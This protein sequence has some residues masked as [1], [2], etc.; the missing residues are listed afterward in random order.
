MNTRSEK[1]FPRVGRVRDN[2][3]YPG[4]TGFTLIEM[5]GVMAIM[6]VLATI[7]VPNTLKSIERAAVRA[8]VETLRNLGEQAK[9]YL[10]DNA[11]PPTAANWNT[12]LG[13]Y[14]SLSPG[15]IL[16][17]RRQ[18]NRIYVVD[19][20][21]ANQR[22][23]MVSSMRSGLLRQA[24]PPDTAPQVAAY[25]GA[26]ATRFNAVWNWNTSAV[27]LTVPA[28][29]GAWNVDNIEYLLIERVNFTPVYRTDLQSFTVSLRNLSGAAVS[30]RITRANGT[31]L[32]P[33]TVPASASTTVTP[34]Y[35][36]DQLSLYRA[37]GAVNLD[38]TY[39]ISTTGKSY[40]FA[41]TN[42]LPQ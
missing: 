40:D 9:L 29:W 24:A 3:P 41:G 23:L 39:I 4:N 15:D 16:T 7:L 22:A 2:A 11:V 32:S 38:F 36:K 37:A 8:E 1:T 27:P 34:L 14:S 6:A 30:Y 25:I 17:N 10:R 12:V 13:T 5:I 19:P 21:A 31:I 18:M 35:P 20:V 28:G 42:W 33:V 26:N